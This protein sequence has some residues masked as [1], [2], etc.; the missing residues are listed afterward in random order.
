MATNRPDSHGEKLSGLFEETHQLNTTRRTR[1]AIRRY[2][3][4]LHLHTRIG[5]ADQGPQCLLSRTPVLSLSGGF[6]YSVL[7]DSGPTPCS[8]STIT[9]AKPPWSIKIH[10]QTHPSSSLVESSLLL[11][12]RFSHQSRSVPGSVPVAPH[13]GPPQFLCVCARALDL[14]GH[15]L[16][17][18]RSLAARCA[19]GASLILRSLSLSPSP[20][21]PPP[22]PQAQGSIPPSSL[23]YPT[24]DERRLSGLSFT[25]PTGPLLS[26]LL[27]P[28]TLPKTGPNAPLTGFRH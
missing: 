18:H 7:V 1:P 4:W 10:H 21:P 13:P 16:F 11:C 19:A 27:A 3:P 22:T 23:P 15:F 24:T 17:S 12:E 20:P 5:C 14:A 8:L 9:P 2:L 28:P 6:S 26:V 25:V